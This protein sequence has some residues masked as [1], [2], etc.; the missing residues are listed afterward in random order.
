[1]TQQDRSSV[2]FADGQVDGAGCAWYEWDA[3]W[4][5]ALADDAQDAVTA[6]EP[7][8]FDVRPARF[9]D[10]QAADSFYE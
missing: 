9:T 4:F 10:P 3:S 8:V 7:E 2:A 1:M 6:F 5:V